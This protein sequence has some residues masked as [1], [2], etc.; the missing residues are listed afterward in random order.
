MREKWGRKQY[1]YGANISNMMYDMAIRSARGD[2]T[3]CRVI[4]AKGEFIRESIPGFG[5]LSDR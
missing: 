5:H 3:Q 1:K 4:L 2:L